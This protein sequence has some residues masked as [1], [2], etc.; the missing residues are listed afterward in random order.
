MP[1]RRPL[2]RRPFLPEEYVNSPR[3]SK[4][5]REELR[6]K[7]KL[8]CVDGLPGTGKT[9]AL[10]E[11]KAAIKNDYPNVPIHIVQ[12]F[13]LIT[14]IL[15]PS[16]PRKVAALRLEKG[17]GYKSKSK[18][19]MDKK[20]PLLSAMTTLIGMKNLVTIRKK[21]GISLVDRSP[22]FLAVMQGFDR[23]EK[24]SSMEIR[25]NA[26]K[27]AKLYKKK[28][29]DRIFYFEPVNLSLIADRIKARKKEA[30]GMFDN[31]LALREF[32]RR[33]EIVVDVFDEQG[34][35]I[36]IIPV[37]KATKEEVA[38]K[39]LIALKHDLSIRI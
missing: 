29:I 33:Y 24:M 5:S 37:E 12:N 36:V 21:P 26:R 27:W 9:T 11:A 8:F 22:M 10:M 18:S 17:K 35:K 28:G 23:G 7:A 4:I 2:R 19:S 32:V 39:L 34:Y 1:A 15:G 16:G 25:R 6:R 31:M 3:I 30:V 13:P 38:N 20:R 14:K